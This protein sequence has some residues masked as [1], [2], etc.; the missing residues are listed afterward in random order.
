MTEQE[1]SEI[2]WLLE[3]IT[4]AKWEVVKRGPLISIVAGT[5]PVCDMYRGYDK[6]KSQQEHDAAFI[7]RA[8]AD[9]RRLLKHIVELQKA[10]DYLNKRIA[11]GID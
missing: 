6:P 4:Q 5:Q 2:A 11:E 8:P 3:L 9:I 1:I 10:N 7:A